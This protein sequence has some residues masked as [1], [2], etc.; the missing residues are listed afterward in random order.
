MQ[1]CVVC[2]DEVRA[3]RGTADALALAVPQ[4]E[5]PKALRRRVMRAVRAEPSPQRAQPRRAPALGWLGSRLSLAGATAIVAAAALTLGLTLGS[6]GS[7]RTLQASVVGLP[8]SAQV[9]VANGRAEL[10]V[11][12]MP[13]PPAGRIYEVW[14]KR[15]SAAP[16]PT[17]TLFSVTRAGGADVGVAGRL[18]G[19]SEV[20]VTPEPAGGSLVPTHTP[21]IV[22][23]LA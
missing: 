13:P 4:Y 22:A 15:G 21:V 23:R 5:A 2:R 18:A 1:S 12:H 17:R 3:F 8:G 19:V 20:L 6:G 14:L 11:T 7:A 9:R 10:I 16:S